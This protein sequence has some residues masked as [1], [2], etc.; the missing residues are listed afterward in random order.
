MDGKKISF[1]FAKNTKKPSL[2]AGPASS[3]SLKKDDSKQM[4]DCL[5][6][7]SIKIIGKTEKEPAPLVIPL[8]EQDKTTIP[9]RLAK[10]LG[11]KQEIHKLNNGQQ[12]SVSTDDTNGE[13]KNEINVKLE[14]PEEREVNVVHEPPK[15]ETLEQR[16]T[17]EIL[18]DIQQSNVNSEQSSNFVVPLLPEDLP[19]DGARESSMDDYESVP[20]AKFG[21]AMLRGMGWKDPDPKKVDPKAAGPDL[22]PAMRPKGLGLGADRAMKAKAINAHLIPP[23]QGETLVMKCGAQV[24]VLAGKHKN[25]YGTVE[26]IDE[27]TSRVIVKFALGGAKEWLNEYMV[28]LVSKQEYNQYAKILNAA[29]Y[30]EFKNREKL[31]AD[32]AE[33][34]SSKADRLERSQRGSPNERRSRDCDRKDRSVESYREDREHPTERSLSQRTDREREERYASPV[35]GNDQRPDGGSTS[36]SDDERNR[37]RRKHKKAS[38]S[39]VR[40]SSGTKKKS[41]KYKQRRE[42]RE[43]RDDSSYGRRDQRRQGSDSESD[44]KHHKK[45]TKKSKK[46]RSRSRSRR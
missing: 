7:Q 43:E 11:I 35:G 8:R 18:E 14:P 3:V 40:T 33:R 10:V 13:S 38:S 24:K 2:L 22:G 12:L 34:T 6:E 37:H 4:I 42:R 16:A 27:E 20:I 28:M 44:G 17:R 30:E 31:E 23:A 46:P 45:K 39:Y 19:L 41:H 29:K 36:D 21:L 26:S 32:E 1:A 9:D 25:A 15:T 5:E